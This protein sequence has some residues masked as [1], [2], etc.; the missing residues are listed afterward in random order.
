MRG[1]LYGTD[2]AIKLINFNKFDIKVFEDFLKEVHLLKKMRH[3]N[4]VNYLI[5]S[6][7]IIKNKDFPN[8]C[9]YQGG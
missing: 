5:Y 9:S 2:V 8:G 6:I 4:I 1:K 7:Y 3:P